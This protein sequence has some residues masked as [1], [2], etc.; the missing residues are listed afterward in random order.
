M[1]ESKLTRKG[2]ELESVF[3]V[4][5]EI[6]TIAHRAECDPMITLCGRRVY[7]VIVAPM[8]SVTDENNYKIWLE[9][10]FICVVPRTVDFEKRIE[11]SKETFASFSLTEAQSL[12]GRALVAGP[13]GVKNKRYVCIDIAH[14][15]MSE[16]YSTCDMLREAFGDKIEIMTGNVANPKA[17]KY[18][19]QHKIDYMRAGIGTG[20]RCVLEG[21]KIKMADGTEENI[22]D[23]DVGDVVKTIDGN[24]KVLKTFHK[25]ESETI[26]VNGDIEVTPNH[27][28][29]VVKK[30]DENKIKSD[31]DILKYGF[32]LEA[33][34]LS[35]DYLLVEG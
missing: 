26:I 16:L 23:I 21:T 7:P 11:I 15:T 14:G 12:A 32:Y 6:S 4:Q 20:S 2:Y 27:K 19:S 3:V 28:F 29:F 22:E 5:A 8:G 24:K 30:E 25:K 18:Y 34:F 35:N 13:D 9:N 1:S 10:N 17:Y 33:R 31:E